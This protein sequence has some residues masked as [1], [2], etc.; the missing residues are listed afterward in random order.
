MKS[1]LS[2]LYPALVTVTCSKI[3]A[4]SEEQ[5][6]SCHLYPLHGFADLDQILSQLFPF[7]TEELHLLQ[8]F[9]IRELL[10]LLKRFQRSSL[11]FLWPQNVPYN[12]A[13]QSG[14]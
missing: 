1:F 12:E 8:S 5:L 11:C 13:Q 14:T 6:C 9:L 4:S 3:T 2:S 10:D 7:H